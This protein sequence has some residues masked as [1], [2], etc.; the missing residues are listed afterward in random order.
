MLKIRNINLADRAFSLIEMIVVLAVAA[1]ALTQAIPHF[2]EMQQ[3]LNRASARETIEYDIS[4]AKAEAQSSGA[5]TI[6][7]INKN[8]SGYTVGFDRAP[9]ADP[10][11]I[12]EV[13]FTRTLPNE[14]YLQLLD[15]GIIM[16]DSRGLLVDAL[17]EPTTITAKLIQES[18]SFSEMKIYAVGRVCYG[19]NCAEL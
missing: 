12:E 13:I 18:E 19:A 7:V 4:R 11:A 17:S 5:R 8:G 10:P 9:V 2:L 3:N 14:V 1:I 15:D 16:F 6:F